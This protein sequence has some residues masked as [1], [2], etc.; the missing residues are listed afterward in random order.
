MPILHTEQTLLLRNS[1]IH[2]RITDLILLNKQESHFYFAV[3]IASI[4]QLNFGSYISHMY[5]LF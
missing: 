5:K 4:S 2:V 3:W 1:K